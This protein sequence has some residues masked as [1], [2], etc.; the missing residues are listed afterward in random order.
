MIQ[1]EFELLM[2][3][4]IK[5]MQREEACDCD[6]PLRPIGID[7]PRVPAQ[8]RSVFASHCSRCLGCLKEDAPYRAREPLPPAKRAKQQGKWN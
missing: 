8:F 5:L 2:A 4:Q 1:R 6:E 7:N 3:A